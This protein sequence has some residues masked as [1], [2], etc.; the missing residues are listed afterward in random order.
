M[1]EGPVPGP[2]RAARVVGAKPNE[3]SLSD[4]SRRPWPDSGNMPSVFTGPSV[5]TVAATQGQGHGGSEQDPEDGR[6]VLTSPSP[7]SEQ[8]TCWA[9]QVGAGFT[10]RI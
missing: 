1:S 10:R 6:I 4:G 3:R 7:H 8:T 5:W 2:R 9:V